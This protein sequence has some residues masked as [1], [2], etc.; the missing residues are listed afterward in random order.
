[1][2][3][4]VLT[5]TVAML[6]ACVST[7]EPAPTATSAIVAPTGSFDAD[8]NALRA[9]NGIGPVV[10]SAL[11]TAIAQAHAED[12]ANRGYFSHQSPGGPN[13]VN[14]SARMAAGG[15][16]PRAGAENIAQGQTTQAQ[17]FVS[18][19]DSP[20]HRANMLGPRYTRYGLGRAGNTWVTVFAAGC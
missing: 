12:M 4:F 15:C 6:A 5:A 16:R 8:L 17:A 3:K 20:G 13:G 7:P 1:M 14:M 19:R 18:W 11:L 9:S 10:Q 2:R